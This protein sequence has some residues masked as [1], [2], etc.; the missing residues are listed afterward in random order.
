VKDDVRGKT[1]AS[2]EGSER[3]IPMDEGTKDER[4]DENKEE[5]MDDRTGIDR[6]RRLETKDDTENSGEA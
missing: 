6:A 3:C 2:V 4:Q 5:A 1:E